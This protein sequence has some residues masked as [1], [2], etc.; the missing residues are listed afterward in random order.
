MDCEKNTYEELVNVITNK[1]EYIVLNDFDNILSIVKRSAEELNISN[2]KLKKLEI[3]NPYMIYSLA[4]LYQDE[5]Y[6]YPICN[7]NTGEVLFCVQVMYNN[8]EWSYEI[9]TEYVNILNKLHYTNYNYV[10]YSLGKTVVADNGLNVHSL[11]GIPLDEYM[12]E[13]SELKMNKKISLMVDRVNSPTY[14]EYE[15]SSC[16]KAAYTPGFLNTASNVVSCSLYKPQGQ[17]N[18]GLCWAA[19]VSTIVNYRKGSNYTAKNFADRM[20]IGYNTGG[21]L[22]N[23]TV[24]L[25]LYGVNYRAINNQIS[26]SMIKENINTK[27]PI[28]VAASSVK[29]GHAVVCFGYKTSDNKKYVYLWNPGTE[30]TSIVLYKSSGTTFT[31]SNVTW[32]WNATAARNG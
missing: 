4:S 21:T 17:G 26:W 25:N 9:S 15:T 1:S 28:Y 10:F 18:Y 19:S 20:G 27:K 16:E 2:E 12:N 6:Y 5:I 23:A 31:Y 22:D 29:G 14:R 11:N 13:F 30:S 3:E 24:A 32:K 7:S 8:G